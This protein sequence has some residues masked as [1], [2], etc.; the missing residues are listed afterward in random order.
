MGHSA[1]YH[2]TI[3]LYLYVT[4]TLKSLDRD[5]YENPE[6]RQHNQ[7]LKWSTNSLNAICI[8]SASSWSNCRSLWRRKKEVCL[9]LPC[10]HWNVLNGDLVW[11]NKS[12]IRAEL[13]HMGSS[14]PR[15]LRKVTSIP[16]SSSTCIWS[17]IISV[18]N[19][20]SYSIPVY[21]KHPSETFTCELTGYR[22]RP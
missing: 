20:L 10:K 3:H 22:T 8:W 5:V 7:K 18:T 13:H 19:E 15:E 17:T 16:L 11:S 12:Y 1:A 21:D 6:D 14:F 9:F 2:C 4:L